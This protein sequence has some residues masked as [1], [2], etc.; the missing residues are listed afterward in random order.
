MNQQQASD[1][2][3]LAQAVAGNADAFG[4][5]YEQ[6]LGDIYHYMF[7]RVDGRQTAE[8]LTETVFLQAWQA[9]D[10]HPPQATHFR[11]WLY[12]IAHNTVVDYYRTRAPVLGLEAAGHVPDPAE[13]PEAQLTRQEQSHALQ[14]AIVQLKEEHQQV[15][16]YRFIVGLSHA[17]TAEIIS[18][19]EEAVRA[20][21]YR[22][23]TALR[24]LL[25]Q[26]DSL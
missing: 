18:R 11:L 17:E 22:A 24:Q 23:M 3:W 25:H 1:A 20:L 5:L 15:L 12:R 8:D 9:L 19:T 14:Q 26:G 13:E 4:R 2:V 7:Y 6:Y 16:I 10:D 21:Q